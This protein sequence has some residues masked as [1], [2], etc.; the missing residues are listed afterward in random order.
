MYLGEKIARDE[1]IRRMEQANLDSIL[2]SRKLFLLV[3]HVTRLSD[4]RILKLE[5]LSS[6]PNRRKTGSMRFYPSCSAEKGKKRRE[7]EEEGWEWIG[8]GR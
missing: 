2:R 8:K 5:N 1:D 7:G 6:D 4:N 3:S